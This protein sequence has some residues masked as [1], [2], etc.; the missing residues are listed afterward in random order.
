VAHAVLQRS[1]ERWGRE[2]STAIVGRHPRLV[3]ALE[4]AARFAR[5]DSPVLI[6]GETGTGKELFARTIY[7]LSGRSRKGELISVNCAQY[8][9]GQLIASELFGHKR[10]S[11]TGA[12]AEHRGI[13]EAAED[14]VVFLDEVGELTLQ[15][16]SMLL[17]LLSEGEIVPV[18]A[19]RP[20]RVNVR[21]IVAT[22][23]DL[24]A[25][26]EAGT[27]RQD[28][29]FRLRQLQL[30]IPPVRDRG[31][32]WQLI[33]AHYLDRLA[34]SGDGH[35]RFSPQAL[36]LLSQ[37]SWPGN[38]REIQ[39]VVDTGFC[40]SEGALIE[41]ETFL[42]SLEEASRMRQLAAVPFTPAPAQSVFSR[43]INQEGTFW[44]LVHVP[45][46]KRD[47]NREQVR[48]VIIQ[49]LAHSGGSYKRLLDAFGIVPQDYLRFMDFL[50][51][52]RLKPVPARPLP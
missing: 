42:D 50:R 41:P 27:F 17:R 14:G 36:E 43:V 8:Q 7:L 30:R 35:K 20:R 48:D 9:E 10:G 45:Y 18:G 1:L 37:H 6:T 33:L 28:L 15:A 2:K 13:F 34:A 51:H 16:Q 21:T 22:N 11:F 46:L 47:L 32:D 39:G 52:H 49:G 4:Q 38:V 29:Y 24:K 26:V 3:A 25:M 40:L 12:V 44:E 5:S 19:S 31:D 23:R